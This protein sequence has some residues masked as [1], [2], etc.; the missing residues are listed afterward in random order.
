MELICFLKSRVL[1]TVDPREYACLDIANNACVF[2]HIVNH[3][4]QWP[5]RRTLGEKKTRYD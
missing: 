4:F 2:P 3:N 1:N 5:G